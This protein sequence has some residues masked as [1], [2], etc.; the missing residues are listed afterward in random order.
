MSQTSAQSVKTATAD[1]GAT[2]RVSQAAQKA[3]SIVKIHNHQIKGKQAATLYVRNLPILTFLNDQAPTAANQT[4]LVSNTA[5]ATENSAQSNRTAPSQAES[6]AAQLDQLYQ[7]GDSAQ[8]IKVVWQGNKKTRK[9]Q[10]V[11]TAGKLPIATIDKNTTYAKTTRSAE[12]DALLI[13]NR[14]RRLLSNGEVK[15]IKTVEGK[16]KP[17]IATP[18]RRSVS[19]GGRVTRVYRGQASWYGPGFH[20]RLTANGERYNQ[21]GI[22]AAHPFLRFG[23]RVR[24]TNQYTGRAVIVRINDRGPYAGGRIIDLSAGAAARIGLKASGVA[25]VSVE[26]LGR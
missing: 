6:I 24:V 16:P 17:V 26:V 10:Y 5:P 20:G 11:V 4:Q 7:A 15:P 14:L 25:P 1:Q 22:T 3:A 8:G 2:V 23:T 18:R 19:A 21:Y 13:A 9:G 12:Q